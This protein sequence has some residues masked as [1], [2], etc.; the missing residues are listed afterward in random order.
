MKKLITLCKML[1]KGAD[2]KIIYDLLEGLKR[3][4]NYKSA[5]NFYHFL[6]NNDNLKIL[7]SILS[8]IFSK[9]LYVFRGSGSKW[10][11]VLGKNIWSLPTCVLD[12]TFE[13]Y[14]LVSR[15]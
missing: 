2:L 3:L 12:T 1:L 5:F 8:W 4:R 6:S 11:K 7:N 14:P 15:I 9:N 13:M 10:I